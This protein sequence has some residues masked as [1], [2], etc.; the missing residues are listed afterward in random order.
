MNNRI[1]ICPGSFDPVTIGHLDV[2][3]RAAG[4]FSK[5][6]VVVMTNTSKHCAFTPDERVALLKK[7]IEAHGLDNV[8]VDFYDGLLADYAKENNIVSI[9]VTA[10]HCHSEIDTMGLWNPF[11]LKMAN[12][13]LAAITGQTLFKTKPGPDEQFM[14][15]LKERTAQSIKNAVE[16]MEEGDLYFSQKDCAEYF[17]D[18]RD[19]TG[20]DGN[21]YVFRFD[22][23]NDEAAETYIVN[24]PAHPTSQVS[25]LTKAQVSSSPVT[26][27]QL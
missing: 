2:I 19:P 9:N 5:V 11:F 10:T 24:E 7:T 3:S 1:A 12:N 18:D 13:A 6:I 14:N 8:E 15:L 23:Y 27:P 16:D 25:R 17:S 4:M 26:T 20:Y 21:M 22:P